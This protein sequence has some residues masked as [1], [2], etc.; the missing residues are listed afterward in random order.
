MLEMVPAVGARLGE[1]RV[2][3]QPV[4][5][6]VV[7]VVVGRQAT[8][9]AF[10]HE[11][12]ETELARADDH[13]RE[14]E[15]QRIRNKRD[16]RDGRGDDAPGMGDHPDATPGRTGAD[17]GELVGGEDLFDGQASGESHA[18]IVGRGRRTRQSRMG[19]GFQRFFLAGAAGVQKAE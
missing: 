12:A 1:D 10:V 13:D 9:R 2:G 19:R 16:K 14:H 6:A 4:R 5:Q 3:A 8:V 11:N 17:A 7:R 15:R 18:A